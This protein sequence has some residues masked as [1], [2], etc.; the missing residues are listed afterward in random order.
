MNAD[1]KIALD[2]INHFA[3]KNISILSI[4]DSF[5]VQAQYKIELYN[6]MKAVYKKHTGF[7]IN[8]K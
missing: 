4:H 7:D 1:S 5:I 8:I 2:V 3:K 6:T